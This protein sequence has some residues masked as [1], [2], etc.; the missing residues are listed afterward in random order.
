MNAKSMYIHIP[1][2]K[3]I[4]SYCDFCKMFYNEKF[5]SPYLLELDKEIKSNYKNNTLDTLYIGG[6]TPSCL[7]IKELN[8]LFNSLKDIK[9]NNNYEF[10]FEM[11]VLDID[12][13]KLKIL[14]DNRV[15]RI[16]IGIETVNEKFMDF[17]ERYNNKEEVIKRINLV[18][19]YFNNYNL[20]LMYAFP[21][22]TV[23]DVL[24][25]LSFV[26]SLNPTHISI[27]SLI[28]EEHT[29]IY[30]NKVKPIDEDLESEMYYNIIDTLEKNGYKHYEIS[31]FAKEGY[32]SRHNLT[33]W[34]NEEYY[35]FGL[36]ASGFINNYRYT[37]TRNIEKYLEHSYI[38]N[39]EKISKEIDMENELIFGLR[40]INGISKKEFKRK[41]SINIEDYFD[42]INLI[43]KNLLIDDQ[44]RLYIPKD[45]LY[46]SNS[47]LVNFIGGKND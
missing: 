28:I 9:L 39:K 13:D 11:N 6:G 41:F 44:D 12:E 27:Y 10:T 37:N 4:C 2:C 32:E 20:D 35:G 15:N 47:I 42:I 5:S 31:N 25:D 34:N 26:I 7:S 38:F 30:I 29:K 8:T 14:K 24:D 3:S 45:K 18:K 40:K 22:E 1:F 16:S 17:L 43:E 33:Y 46:V 23:K 21:N 36:G 19:K